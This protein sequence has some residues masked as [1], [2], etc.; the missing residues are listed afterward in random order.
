M[1][2]EAIS[3]PKSCPAI[4]D[5]H[6]KRLK[7]WAGQEPQWRAAFQVAFFGHTNQP[8]YEELENLWQA[9]VLRFVGPKAPYPNLN[10]ELTNC[11]GLA[12]MSNLEI[13]VLTNHRVE[14]ID[15][16]AG[17]PALKSLFVNNNALRSLDGIGELKQVEQLYAQVN[18]IESLE[19]MRNLTNLREV[20]VNFNAL[21]TLNGVTRKHANSLKTFFCLP[22]KYLP[23][24]ET[25]R[26]E[27][28]LGIRCRSL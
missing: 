14:T 9:P 3:P 20:H 13:L 26:V 8:T 12:G 1:N 4:A 6:A 28:T 24:R 21:T 19:P 17:M 18:R 11:S 10:F 23:D 16:V 15:E 2:A 27:Q 7:W 25:I 5:T 22:N